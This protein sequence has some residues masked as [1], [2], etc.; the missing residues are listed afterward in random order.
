M[1]MYNNLIYVKTTLL[2][3]DFK[4]NIHLDIDTLIVRLDSK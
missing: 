2:V 3:D 1:Y 4:K